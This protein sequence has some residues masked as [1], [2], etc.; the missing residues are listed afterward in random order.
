MDLPRA[1]PRFFTQ[2]RPADRSS[3]SME[4]AAPRSS[5]SIEN[6]PHEPASVLPSST[7]LNSSSHFETSPTQANFARL[8][9]RGL[10]SAESPGDAGNLSM[11]K[12]KE[13]NAFDVLDAGALAESRK[14]RVNFVDEQ[15]EESDEDNG[16]FFPQK[17]EGDDEEDSGDEG[18]IKE[19]VDDAALTAEEKS[20]LAM[21]AAEKHR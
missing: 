16:W 10:A 12:A 15:A 2:T 18:Y 17:D 3:P 9:R 21:Q 6:A 13:V 11:V 4:D 7:V 5:V 14:G 1:D 20:R 8:R 19:L